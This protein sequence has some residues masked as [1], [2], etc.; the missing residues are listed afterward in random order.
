MTTSCTSINH[1]TT[2]SSEEVTTPFGCVQLL[3][4]IQESQDRLADIR[5][6]KNLI[7]IF[8]AAL[9]SGLTNKY[10][11]SKQQRVTQMTS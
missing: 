3:G 1:I 8:S 10:I 4:R 6:R 9:I 2:T 7:V 11:D 5:L